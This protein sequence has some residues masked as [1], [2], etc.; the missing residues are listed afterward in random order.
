MKK[1][2]ADKIDVRALAYR[3]IDMLY[4]EGLVNAETYRNVKLLERQENG[5]STSL[6]FLKD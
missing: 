2:M 5:K 1:I 3:L 6:T 4:Q